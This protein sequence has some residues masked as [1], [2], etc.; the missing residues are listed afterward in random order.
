MFDRRPA[1]PTPDLFDVPADGSRGL[2][3]GQVAAFPIA[4]TRGLVIGWFGA[5][6]ANVRAIA[7]AVR[8]SLEGR[9]DDHV[10]TGDH[11]RRMVTADPIAVTGGICSARGR[12]THAQ[13][14][15][16]R[17]CAGPS[18]SSPADLRSATR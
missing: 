6:S 18:V 8:G 1:R 11:D 16:V 7:I 17:T 2:L 9:L 4:A 14:A 13:L 3:D 12:G 10:V 5:T 15:A